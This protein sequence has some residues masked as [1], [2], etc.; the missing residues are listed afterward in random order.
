MSSLKDSFKTAAVWLG[1][2]MAVS[3]PFN[4]GGTV[5]NEINVIKSED[6]NL[7]VFK[8]GSVKN[9]SASYDF[10][11]G[12]RSIF[13]LT[14]H[15]NWETKH[16]SELNPSQKTQYDSVHREACEIANGHPG[17]SRVCVGLDF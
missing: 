4:I 11:K 14:P 15:L 6:E 3:F 10:E 17:Y 2:G 16:Y 13:Q 12:T 5:I 1:I 7:R 9:G 8:D